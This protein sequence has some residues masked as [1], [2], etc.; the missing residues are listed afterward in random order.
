MNIFLSIDAGSS[1]IKVIASDEHGRTLASAKHEIDFIKTNSVFSEFEIEQYWS[2]CRNML[3]FVCQN[4]KHLRKNINSISVC[5]HG[6]TFVFLDECDRVL[7]PAV[8]WIDSR[9]QE[10][11]IYL[12]KKIEQDVYYKITGQPFVNALYVSSKLLWFNNNKKDLLKKTKKIIFIGDYLVFKLTGKIRTSYSLSSVSGLLDITK[13]EWSGLILDAVRI[14][15]DKM[16]PLLESGEIVETIKTDEAKNL[17]IPFNTV[18][19]STA[20][21]QAATALGAGNYK[22]NIIVET[23]GTVLA[24]STI[25]K[26]NKFDL[27]RKIPVFYHSLKDKYLLLPWTKNGGIVLSWFKNT[28]MDYRNDKQSYSFMDCEA[29]EAKPGC[30]GLIFLPYVL[31]ADF[32]FF[33]E[34]THGCFV[35][36]KI[37][38]KRAHFIRAVLES[39]GYIIDL[40]IKILKESGVKCSSVYSIGGGSKSC[41]WM[42][43]KADILKQDIKL[44]RTTDDV[45]A[46][47]MNMLSAISLGV[48]KNIEEAFTSMNSPVNTF[49]PKRQHEQVY[50]KNILEFERL[51]SLFFNNFN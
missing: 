21:D 8:F 39:I 19:M 17:G 30:D 3:Y 25:I 27:K 1:F 36:I 49:K 26:K 32:P 31:G 43:I 35:G 5:S 13:K 45:G 44:L 4:L 15:A 7:I 50:E 18:I 11:G 24:I 22:E 40:N 23:T 42:Q 2:C 41:I 46:L 6:S 20:L 34:D 47:G 28:F 10:E 33:Q 38:H 9:A 14:D 51:N 16:P 29:A 12:S 37:H 48:Y